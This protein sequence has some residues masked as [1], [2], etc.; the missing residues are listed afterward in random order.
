MRP[1]SDIWE[2]GELKQLGVDRRASFAAL[3]VLFIHTVCERERDKGEAC[4][5]SSSLLGVPALRLALQPCVLPVLNYSTS[6]AILLFY[7]RVFSYCFSQFHALACLQTFT[8][9]T[10]TIIINRLNHSSG[11]QT[12]SLSVC[13]FVYVW[14]SLPHIMTDF[15]KVRIKL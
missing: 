10:Q 1:E 3:W 14:V 2:G 6:R 5:C 8:K 4:V 7:L 9:H 12:G 15:T 13:V 11:S